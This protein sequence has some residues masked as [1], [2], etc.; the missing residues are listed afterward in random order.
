MVCDRT[1]VDEKYDKNECFHVIIHTVLW[2]Q[3]CRA[4]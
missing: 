1:E 4:F 2:C 3:K